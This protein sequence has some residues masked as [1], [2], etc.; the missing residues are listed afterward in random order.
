MVKMKLIK[1]IKTVSN[2]IYIY[3]SNN[4]LFAFKPSKNMGK[5]ILA[6]RLAGLFGIKILK[7]K[8]AEIGDKKGILM[9]YLKDST[10]LMR[11]ENQLNKKQIK[12]LKRII[13]FDIWIGN[14]DRHTA[15][16][17]V[18]NDDLIAFDHEKIL[19]KGQARN[20]IKM[21]TG[22]KLNKSY[23]D[24]IEKLLDKDLTAK[25]VLQK[26]GFEEED[27]IEIKEEDIRALVKD[28]NIINFLISR[29]NFNR[30]KF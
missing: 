7:I 26:I 13:L 30:I 18:A 24:I 5:E 17:L 25:Q 4:D 10:L 2:I 29:S 1:T 14:K 23:V 19:Q 3:K 12:Q 8:P 16:I 21:D 27:F 15:N 20:F 9:N 11:Y 22:R 28:K 6:N